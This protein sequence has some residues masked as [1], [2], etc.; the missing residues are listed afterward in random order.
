VSVGSDRVSVGSRTNAGSSS[1]PKNKQPKRCTATKQQ[2][3]FF[4]DAVDRADIGALEKI[5]NLGINANKVYHN[6]VQKMTAVH[7]AAE[8]GHV[9]LMK[10][11]FEHFHADTD[12][13]DKT[14][15]A[16]LH[17][18]VKHGNIETVK[19]LAGPLKADL[20][21]LDN[22]KRTPLYVAAYWNKPG[23]TRELLDQIIFHYPK[24]YTEKI[25]IASE[26]N[27]TPWDV[28]VGRKHDQIKE[29]IG[30][31]APILGYENV[32]VSDTLDH[33]PAPYAAAE[34][35]QATEKD[36]QE[37]KK[38]VLTEKGLSPLAEFVVLDID[39][40]KVMID[41]FNTT[42][43][44]VAARTGREHVLREL[45]LSFSA[46]VN[47]VNSRGETPLHLA[48]ANSHGVVI[49]HLIKDYK[50]NPN[51]VDS[52]GN[53][54]FHLACDHRQREALE[55]LFEVYEQ[56]FG[57]AAMINEIMKKNN[58]GDTALDLI[59]TERNWIPYLIELFPVECKTRIPF[60]EKAQRMRVYKAKQ[61]C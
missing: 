26:K 59:T 58:A 23:A 29:M 36:V 9:N 50:A 32:R 42:A 37:F 48:T 40:N 31:A 52:N 57:K 54:V 35:L 55:V 34:H 21:A 41:E 39:C 13:R 51:P 60:V 10:Y 22:T 27:K 30:S 56:H 6:E 17:Y 11:L 45:V 3:I 28:A 33:V 16:P 4:K 25:K 46:D 15:A 43:Q 19:L 12:A 14:G 24:H 61:M 49:R 18:A 1:S 2:I 44:H 5:S 47:V 20:C 7:K 38:A 53:T 8:I